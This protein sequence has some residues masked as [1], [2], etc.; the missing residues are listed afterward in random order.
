MARQS[1]LPFSPMKVPGSKLRLMRVMNR[2]GIRGMAMTSFFLP[3]SRLI[4]ATT[5]Q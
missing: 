5:T 1:V 4:M 3:S 2:S